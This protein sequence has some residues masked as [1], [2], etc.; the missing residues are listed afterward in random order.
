MEKKEFKPLIEEKKEKEIFKKWQDQKLFYPTNDSKKPKFS[1]VLPPPNVTGHL[2]I[3]HAWDA[4][5]QD[6]MIRYKKLN[7]YNV[8]W[9]PGTDHAGIS[10]QTKFEKVL[11][12]KGDDKKNYKE[13]EF[14]AKLFEWCKEQISYIHEQW[15][16]LGLSLCYDYEVFTLDDNANKLINKEF[17]KLYNDGLIYRKLKLTNWDIKQQTAISDLEVIMKET[18]S[19]LWYFKYA[20]ADNP[21][22]FIEVATTRPETMFVDTNIVVHPEDKRFTKF[23]GKYVIN[24]I[25]DEKILVI[26]DK[27]IDIKFGTGAMKLTP[28]CDFFDEQIAKR[29]KITKFNCCIDLDGKLNKFAK[30]KFMNFVGVD[31]IVAREKIVNNIKER[32]LLTKEETHINN[33][34]YSERSGEVVEPLLTKQWFVKMKP[35][36]KKFYQLWKKENISF[37]PS[38]F[39]NDLRRWCDNIQDWCISRQLLWGHTIPAWYNKKTNEIYVGQKE[40]KNKEEWI[41]EKDVLDTWFSSG[42]WPL[43]TTKY[44]SNNKKLLSKFY[45][46]SLLSTGRDI[47]TFWVARMFFQCVYID[48]TLP[49]NTIYI[50]GLIRDENGLKMSK[51]WGNVIDPF[52]IINK[53]GNDPW[54]LGI[55]SQTT[56]NGDDIN[57][58]K[59]II[60]FAWSFQNKIINAKNL[61]D[62][63]LDTSDIDFSSLHPVN[64]WIVSSFNSFLDSFKKNMD[65]WE[66]NNAVNLI[67]KFVWEVFCNKYLE[68]QKKMTEVDKQTSKLVKYLYNEI[69]SAISCFIPFTSTYL[70]NRSD[71]VFPK[72]IKINEKKED[73]KIVEIWANAKDYRIKHGIKNTQKIFVYPYGDKVLELWNIFKGEKEGIYCEEVDNNSS[74]EKVKEKNI[75][76]LKSDIE[77]Y[78]KRLNPVLEKKNPVLYKKFKEEYDQKV[79]EL[80][81]LQKSK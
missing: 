65:K 54:R 57:F 20:L 33:V 3:G 9:I 35:I 68:I 74:N 39:E 50:H 62:E 40:P 56:M 14:K 19:K 1:I 69:L 28:A 37:I 80:N 73:S 58:N 71:F 53:Y 38:R 6:C 81:L 13:Q 41:K 8:C 30:N 79:N 11:K 76:Q 31:R 64:I 67:Y 47:L 77:I 15:Y 49:I 10:A 48:N 43:T 7:G 55:L 44:Q 25:N 72:K 59:N 21:K 51:S 66:F 12:E 63:N 61:I 36:V 16:R 52:D 17:I 22:L 2:H 75:L 24:P 23:V 78:E 4:C 60:E 45:P 27:E 46:I 29:N 18:K 32:G 42:L 70:L 26:T 5:V 34:G